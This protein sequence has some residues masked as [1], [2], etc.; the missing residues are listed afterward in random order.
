MPEWARGKT[1]AELLGVTKALVGSFPR[2][3]T[4]APPP[5]GLP[6][7]S[8]PAPKVLDPEGYVTGKDFTEA[9]SAFQSQ[10]RGDV[11]SAVEMAAN[12]NFG[13]TRNQYQKEFARYLP[14]IQAKLSTVP[15]RL[16]TLDNL[17]T[18]VKIVRADHFDDYRAEWQTEVASKMDPTIRSTGGGGSVPVTQQ[19]K[20]LSLDSEKIPVEWKVR[21]QQKGISEA[22]VQEFCRANE[23]SEIDFYKQFETP[24]N[25]I[26]GDRGGR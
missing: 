25:A 4:T 9:A 19:D 3:G 20:S 2:G 17:E 1:A 23:M 6:P 12:A 24:M 10:F 5:S 14:E 7:V 15:K 21:A 16:W 13:L 22:T 8:S 18:V 11:D 26:V